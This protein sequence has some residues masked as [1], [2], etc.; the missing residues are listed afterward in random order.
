MTPL[1]K[2]VLLAVAVLAGAITAI[3]VRL[4][5]VR[6]VA[7]A[8]PTIYLGVLFL[9]VA[10][11]LLI[12]GRLVV[13]YR[14]GTVDLAPTSA[15]AIAAFANVAAW[16]GAAFSGILAGIAGVMLSVLDY[17]SAWDGAFG[18]MISGGGAV[19]MTVVAVIVEWWC[20]IGDDDEHGD[21]RSRYP[22]GSS[23]RAGGSTA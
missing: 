3:V 6:A 20:R 23:Q 2:R 10:V 9:A 21:H 19:A 12:L 14:R 18:A 1:K 8:S 22:R 16:V 13:G 15:A 11:A 4:L 7:V 17:S 5:L